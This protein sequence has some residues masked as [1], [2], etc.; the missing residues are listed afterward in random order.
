MSIGYGIYGIDLGTTNSSI[1][2]MLGNEVKIVRNKETDEVTPSVVKLNQVNGVVVEHIGRRA[3]DALA[4]SPVGVIQRAKD[5]M[6]VPGSA[7]PVPGG[8]RSENA[9]QISARILREMA[10]SVKR[11]PGLPDPRGAVITVPAIFNQAA[12]D[13]TRKAGMDAGFSHVELYPEPAAAALAFG[14]KADTSRGAT[15]LA[16]DL[17]GGTFDCALVRAEDG[18]FTVLDTWGDRRLGGG[19][20]DV[21]ILKR[22]IIPA[23][24]TAQR[25]RISADAAAE[26]GRKSKYW[27]WLL[28]HAELAKVQL[29]VDNV[30]TIIDSMDD[31]NVDC[32][33]RRE[34]V[35]A[36]QVELFGRTI[37]LCMTLLARNNFQTHQIERVLMVG[38]PTR[39]AFLRRMI[40][41]GAK[42]LDGRR[43]E[44]LN[45]QLDHSVDP[46]T[47]VAQGAALY[48]VTRR[49]PA[50]ALGKP[51][52]VVV[53]GRPRIELMA[54][55]AVLPDDTDLLVPGRVIG[56]RNEP[57][58]TEGWAVVIER[59]DGQV[60]GWYSEPVALT[61]TGGF[62]RRVPLQNGRNYF[63]IRVLNADQTPFETDDSAKFEVYRGIQPGE[64]IMEQGLGIAD[65]NGETIWFFQKGHHLPAGPK[66]LQFRTKVGLTRGGTERI[67]IPI[68]EGMNTKAFLNT[69]VM[70]F[71]IGYDN[72]KGA[73]PKDSL[74]D[75]T[76]S[77]SNDKKI[78]VLAK[79]V[80]AK[81]VVEP[82]DAALAPAS[83]E[84]RRKIALAKKNHDLFRQV[85]KQSKAIDKVVAKIDDEMLLIECDSLLA[86]GSP[87]NL[88]PW[89]RASAL[90][91]EVLAA[92]EPHLVSVDQLL[93]WEV[94]FKKLREN[95]EVSRRIVKEEP[96]PAAWKAEFDELCRRY[97]VAAA[98]HNGEEAELISYTLIPAHFEKL[99]A[100]KE[101][102]GGSG[103]NLAIGAGQTSK[104][105]T[106]GD[107]SLGS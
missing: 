46:M 14:H 80:E 72:A 70:E 84:L 85:R 71:T 78:H 22:L 89:D 3:R 17:G 74:I 79:F 49:L 47:A 29:D 54:S 91:Q 56:P 52:A 44:G 27:W 92:Q 32:N 39:S 51:D 12:R 59:M 60:V 26:S 97:E 38:G 20:L 62:T 5:F 43:I 65:V 81:V 86:E 16:Y 101:R 106:R 98:N 48:A 6:G 63:Q 13:D 93:M 82:P 31:F 66:T 58:E 41:W 83:E 1:A 104:Q 68:V 35:E 95:I 53:T 18:V 10:G 57:L 11:T 23:L 88:L 100:L 9:V 45:I 30:T 107:L 75:L 34:D 96:R 28:R 77:L 50:E 55:H 103:G 19:N 99:P 76:M 102:V 61:L 69:M 4:S 37:M 2:I 15:W 42:G 24:P 64:P 21:E 33:L 8:G 40:E 105:E 73:F 67:V 25:E 36:L 87:T 7:F 94:K 90:L